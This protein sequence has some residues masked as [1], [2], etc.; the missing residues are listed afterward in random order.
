M[1]SDLRTL[2]S[3][4]FA[5]LAAAMPKTVISSALVLGALAT[6]SAICLDEA[7]AAPEVLSDLKGMDQKSI[8]A[9]L[10]APDERRGAGQGR[11][12]WLYGSS[13]L[14]F[15]DGR[16]TAWSDAGELLSRRNMAK[17]KRGAAGE[18]ESVSGS[19]L[20]WRNP[21]TPWQELDA[22]QVVDELEQ[23]GAAK[24]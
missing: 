6:G 18:E 15:R 12:S 21:W 4:V 17:V 19:S 2:R 23:R 10:G 3:R 9:E 5:A 16:V 7:F 13:V 14:L 8:E 11:E 22:A 24:R 20:I 1:L